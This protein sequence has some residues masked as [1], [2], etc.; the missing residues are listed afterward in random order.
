MLNAG[1]VMMMLR[2]TQSPIGY[3]AVFVFLSFIM[4][5]ALTVLNMLIGVLCEVVTAVGQHERDEADIR[6]VKQGILKELIKF[7][8][9]GS[10]TISQTEL[11]A[12]MQSRRA[13][14]VLEEMEVDKAAPD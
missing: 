14:A 11:E 7:D 8:V 2:D 13:Q 6:L 12:A 10:G 1:G 3:L 9:D 5:S 4:L